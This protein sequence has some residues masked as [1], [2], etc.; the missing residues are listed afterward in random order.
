VE[1]SEPPATPPPPREEPAA[2]D[3]LVKSDPLGLA[4]FVDG[5]ERGVSPL[6]LTLPSGRTYRLELRRGDTIV[7]RAEV[8]LAPGDTEEIEIAAAAPEEAR[9]RVVSVPS[10]ATV[11]VAGEPA[12]VT[13]LDV[14]TAPGEYV[15]EVRA[16]G[17]RTQEGNAVLSEPGD[18]ATLSFVLVRAPGS[19]SNTNPDRPAERGGNGTLT[20]ATT[21]YSEVYLG[22][23]H[24]G[25]TPFRGVSLPAGAHT[26]RL[27]SP[28]R[29]SRRHRVVIEANEETRV[30]LSL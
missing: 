5:Q 11:L 7:G 12:G 3:L 20:V 6:A 29:P 22:G 28:G 13:P 27:E 26:L 16:E 19:S 21:P 25:T 8:D 2:A 30:R 9:L 1:P 18:T 17:Y 24:L 14:A 4:V 23:R 15:V 10:G